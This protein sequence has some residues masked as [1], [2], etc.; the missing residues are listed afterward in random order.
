MMPF[1]QLSRRVPLFYALRR[2]FSDCLNILRE[3]K[4]QLPSA[5]EM[6]QKHSPYVWTEFLP[7]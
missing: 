7:G 3:H 4:A 2:R 6:S 1:N 5:P